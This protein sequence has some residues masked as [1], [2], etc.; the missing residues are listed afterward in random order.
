MEAKGC[1]FQPRLVGVGFLAAEGLRGEAEGGRRVP[2]HFSVLRP[3]APGAV[4]SQPQP[5]AA[6][7]LAPSP[8]FRHGN[9]EAQ[10]GAEIW[11]V[12]TPPPPRPPFLIWGFGTRT[13]ETIREQCVHSVIRANW[14]GWEEEECQAFGASLNQPPM[15]KESSP[16]GR[17]RVNLE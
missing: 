10:A 14:C 4:Q 7:P 13:H 12:S 6:W 11:R 9:T 2:D 15:E 3:R 1:D 5:V 16:W 8:S 17:G